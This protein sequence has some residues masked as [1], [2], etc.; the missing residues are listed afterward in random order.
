MMSRL[1]EDIE[2]L[3][4]VTAIAILAIW[5]DQHAIAVPLSTLDILAAEINARIGSPVDYRLIDDEAALLVLAARRVTLA[6]LDDQPARLLRWAAIGEL[7]RKACA[8]DLQN[9]I[10]SAES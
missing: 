6:R 9:A 3:Q 5:P 7:A 8:A 10:K 4:R 2:L 1:D